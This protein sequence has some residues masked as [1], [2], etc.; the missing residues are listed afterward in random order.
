LLRPWPPE[1]L[2]SVFQHNVAK[3]AE[4]DK[5]AGSF[6]PQ[7]KRQALVGRVD[8]LFDGDPAKRRAFLEYVFE[9]ASSAQMTVAMADVLEN[10]L[11][12]NDHTGAEALAVV[13]L[14][15]DGEPGDDTEAKQAGLPGL[16]AA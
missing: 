12:S 3:R 6:Y 11:D 1:P 13:E 14:E 15:G 16:E 7:K 2:K 5:N 4:K 8:D 10:W 9:I